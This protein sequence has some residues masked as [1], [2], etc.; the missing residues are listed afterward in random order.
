MPKG[1]SLCSDTK[2]IKKNE[3]TFNCQNIHPWKSTFDSVNH[4]FVSADECRETKNG[5]IC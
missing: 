1:Y 2:V 3:T 4:D 5:E